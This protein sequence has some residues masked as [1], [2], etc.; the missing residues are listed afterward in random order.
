VIEIIGYIAATFSVVAFGPQAWKVIKTRD[1]KTLS[2]PMWVLEILAFA[3]WVAYGIAKSAL[4]IVIPN[5]ICFILAVFIL[6]M[7]LL[8]EHK[9][10]AVADKLDP[11]V[12]TGS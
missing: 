10:H 3:T 1:T 2:T 11:S 8:P 4:P 6:V 7:K 12:S 5:V 9:K